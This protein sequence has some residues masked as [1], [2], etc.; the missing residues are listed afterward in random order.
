MTANSRQ[1]L[2]AGDQSLNIQVANVNVGLTYADVRDMVIDLFKENF[3]KLRKEAAAI[4]MERAEEITDQ[5]LNKLAETHPEAISNARD[6]DMQMALLQVQREYARSGDKELGELLVD[7]LVDRSSQAGRSMRQ[8]VLNEA[9]NAAPRLTVAGINI[10]SVIWL[11]RN[12]RHGAG[13]L[14][15][16]HDALRRNLAPFAGVQ[17]SFTEL[18][19]LE[20]AGCVSLGI[21]QHDI[22]ETTRFTYLGIF[23]NGF[24]KYDPDVKGLPIDILTPCLRNPR[25]R[26]QLNALNQQMLDELVTQFDLEDR[27]QHLATL[28]SKGAMT[29]PEVERELLKA[30]PELRPIVDTWRLSL[31]KHADLT[32]VGTAIGHA[33]WRRVT[34]G[35]QDIETWLV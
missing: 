30:I 25:K 22:I 17:A 8:L 9:L 19:H 29:L 14:R 20:Y 12:V 35:T 32:S 26:V 15:E 7:M 16:L 5:F 24:S 23:T 10:L 2:R 33:N 21:A 27:K 4:A 11:V 6:P 28:L 13:N 18:R 1:Q 31:M 3:P 34:G